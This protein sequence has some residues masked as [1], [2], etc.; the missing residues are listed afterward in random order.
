MYSQIIKV[1]NMINYNTVKNIYIGQLTFLKFLCHFYHHWTHFFV[2]NF[3]PLKR[4][5]NRPRI[6]WTNSQDPDVL[7]IFTPCPGFR[8]NASSW[9]MFLL[10]TLSGAEIAPASAF[11]KVRRQ[12]EEDLTSRIIWW[13]CHKGRSHHW[14]PYFSEGL[15]LF[16]QSLYLINKNVFTTIIYVT[17][18][19]A[20]ITGIYND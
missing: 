11:K 6:Y 16:K 10:R 12:P 19:C 20:K 1:L 7:M 15:L 4:H 18:G 13:T 5:K 2:S 3:P 14:F 9:P 8:M 17:V